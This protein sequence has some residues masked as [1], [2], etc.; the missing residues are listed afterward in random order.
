[1]RL[2]DLLKLS[3]TKYPSRIA[4]K[5]DNNET[6]YAQLLSNVERLSSY[7]KSAGCGLGVKI[8][9][10]LPNHEAYFISFF[11][12]SSAQAT[13]VAMSSKMTAYEV[14]DFLKR[15]DVSMAITN[16]NFAYKLA[17]QLNNKNKIAILTIEQ[18]PDSTFQIETFI[19]APVQTDAENSDV[20][21]MVY[22]S[23]T[24]GQSKI[25]MLTDDQLISNMLSYRAVMNFDE[26]NI[27]YCSLLL[28]HIYC[29]CAQLL[30]H[31]SL[32]HTFIVTNTPFFIKDFFKAVQKHQVTITAFVPYLATLMAEYPDH[33]QFDITSL[34]YITISGSKT[35][36]LVYQKLTKTFS[37]IKFINTYGMSEAGSRI[38]IAGPDP[39][40]FP[41]ESVG[42]AIPKVQIRITN[43]NK[44]PLPAN[45][46]GEV[47]VKGIGIFKGYYNQPQLTK[48]TIVKGW[49]KTGDLG[50]LD[51]L[52]NLFLVGRKKEMILCGGE[53]I[54]PAEIEETILENP[55]VREAAVIALPDDRLEEAPYAFV[56][57]KLNPVS[58]ADIINFCR[59]RL[60]SFKVP[61]NV[62]FIDELPK[63]GSSKIDKKK[64]KEIA[65]KKL[66]PD[67]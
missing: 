1:M 67:L 11:A 40:Q 18:N 31:I 39:T 20:A 10:A 4:I 51:T 13:I 28:H 27:V 48:E 61:R 2:I 44:K 43:E 24:T 6:T 64:L 34:K 8:A 63:L 42:R 17:D 46:I 22:T 52:N 58:Q 41:I 32:S 19:S 15:A 66:L 29:I 54:F 45:C 9:I 62:F 25:V 38:S 33:N 65:L 21:L 53:N 7:L 30:T 16:K 12:I 55:S 60:S 26:H 36:K 47:E 23:G 59:K 35:P 5:D 3:S 57:I 14:A 50:K 49:M 56:V 37:H